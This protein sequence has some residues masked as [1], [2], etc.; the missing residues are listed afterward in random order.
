[1]RDGTITSHRHA[2]LSSWLSL[3]AGTLEVCVAK[4]VRAA[5]PPNCVWSWVPGAAQSRLNR[6]PRNASGSPGPPVA[7]GKY[8]SRSFQAE[9]DRHRLPFASALELGWAGLDRMSCGIMKSRRS[10]P[11]K[12]AGLTDRRQWTRGHQTGGIKGLSRNSPASHPRGGPV[13]TSYSLS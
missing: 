1:M 12:T 4:P 2:G 11:D 5:R 7:K 8:A 9:E 13:Q 3:R 6:G 10:S